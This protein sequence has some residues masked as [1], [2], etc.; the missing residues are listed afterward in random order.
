M[1][2]T[3]MTEAGEF[4]EIYSLDVVEIPTNR[5]MVRKDRTTRSI[6]TAKEKYDADR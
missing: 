3:A 1:T 5:E 4:A 2:G 6:R